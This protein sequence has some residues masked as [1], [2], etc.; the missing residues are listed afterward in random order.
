M[1]S[2]SCTHLPYV[3]IIYFIQ[4]TQL[5]HFHLEKNTFYSY[6]NLCRDVQLK[7][8]KKHRGEVTSGNETRI[9]MQRSAGK[10][11]MN[12]LAAWYP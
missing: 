4:N 7:C 1:S 8:L 3:Y 11:T 10:H 9:K 12:S 6:T 5:C 2:H